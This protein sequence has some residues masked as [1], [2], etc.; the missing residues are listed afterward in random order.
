MLTTVEGQK[1]DIQNSEEQLKTKEKE[2]ELL[3]TE[4]IK[5]IDMRL[6]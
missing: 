2:L 4:F 3:E 6:K 1:K 5:D